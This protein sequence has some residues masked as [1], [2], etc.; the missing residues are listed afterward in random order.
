MIKAEHLC[1]NQSVETI[2]TNTSTSEARS[3]ITL[4]ALAISASCF[5]LGAN[6][7]LLITALLA[8]EWDALEVLGYRVSFP[9]S[10]GVQWIA[11]VTDRMFTSF[12]KNGDQ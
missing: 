11:K 5:L 7:A 6:A 9:L 1:Q 2:E 12:C 10:A 8:L 4:V 3:W